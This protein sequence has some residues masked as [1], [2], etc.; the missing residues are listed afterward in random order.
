MANSAYLLRNQR[1]ASADQWGLLQSYILNIEAASPVLLDIFNFNN[2]TLKNVVISEQV[3]TAFPTVLSF[4]YLLFENTAIQW[5]MCKCIALLTV[6]FLKY[7]F[8]IL[9]K[10]VFISSFWI[11]HWVISFFQMKIYIIRKLS[12][13][14]KLTC[15]FSAYRR[16]VNDLLWKPKNSMK[17]VCLNS[18][19]SNKRQGRKNWK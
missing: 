3:Y 17:S 11:I 4:F 6:R 10:C 14:L 16:V 19:P 18:F 7:V 5:T 15:L 12:E 2:S 8:S 1:D 13:V 9:T